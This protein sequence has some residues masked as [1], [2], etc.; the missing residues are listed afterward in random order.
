MA[1]WL[2][3][4]VG[5]LPGPGRG[6]ARASP[7]GCLPDAP[8]PPDQAPRAS[9]PGTGDERGAWHDLGTRDL[10]ALGSRRGHGRRR[11][12]A[13]DARTAE[14]AE[15]ELAFRAGEDGSLEAAYRRYGRIVY[16]FARRATGDDLADELTQDVFL[17][18]WSSAARFDPDRGALAGWLIG[19]ARHKAV[20]ALRRRE[21][22]AAR[23]ERAG[24]LAGP[25]PSSAEVDHLAERLAVGECLRRLRPDAREVV[26]LA[27]WS[28]LTHEQI[29]G[30]RTGR[31]L[32]T[33]KAQIRRSLGA[34]RRY[35]EGL[36]AAP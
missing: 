17:A 21:R 29:A 6:V 27:F 23:V 34:M 35:L 19:I 3:P 25:P 32:G 30:R 31:P 16:T 5:P 1:W 11:H 28:D 24:A 15:L 8:T 7:A 26:E 13:G 22:A 20:D 9:P 10:G 2:A 14:D 33:V 36:D 4:V 18:A 12:D